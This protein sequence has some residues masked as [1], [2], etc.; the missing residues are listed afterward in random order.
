VI[1]IDNQNSYTLAERDG[2]E[3]YN[4]I[5]QTDETLGSPPHD[6]LIISRDQALHIYINQVYRGTLQPEQQQGGLGTAIVN[7]E[8]SPASCIYRNLW[9]W[10]PDSN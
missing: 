3:Y 9:L 4:T 7:Y 2:D 5:F 10:K 6:I 8:D 1:F